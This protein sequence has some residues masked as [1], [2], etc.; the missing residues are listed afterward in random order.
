[1]P[2][3]HTDYVMEANGAEMSAVEF[4]RPVTENL[5]TVGVG[6]MCE[7]D[8]SGTSGGGGIS[9]DGTGTSSY[10]AASHADQRA[11]IGARVII[12]VKDALLNNGVEDHVIADILG[13]LA[14]SL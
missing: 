4:R 13:R 14:M 5:G 3:W 12:A 10:G 1:M 2:S 8:I 6:G 11:A 7:D 9:T